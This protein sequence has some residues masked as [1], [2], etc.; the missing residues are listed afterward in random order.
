MVGQL[1]F[2]SLDLMGGYDHQK[3]IVGLMIIACWLI[4]FAYAVP[5]HKRI[6]SDD[7]MTLAIR[8][9]I[10]VNWYRTILWS[11]IFLLQLI[12]F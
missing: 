7:D 12:S 10:K 1:V 11:L 5:L 9:L 8:S 3:S 6:D 2:H 4:T